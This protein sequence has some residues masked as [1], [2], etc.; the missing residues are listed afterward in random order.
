MAPKK[1]IK[2]P[3]A[4]KKRPAKKVPQKPEILSPGHLPSDSPNAIMKGAAPGAFL[5]FRQ[6]Q[7]DVEQLIAMDGP[8]LR[9][10][11]MK[12]MELASLQ[13]V[14]ISNDLLKSIAARETT[15]DARGM[16][17]ARL[18]QLAYFNESVTRQRVAIQKAGLLEVKKPEEKEK[19]PADLTHEEW[20][21]EYG[22][23]LLSQ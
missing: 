19:D 16:L 5:D 14:K 12:H 10:L 2:K 23:R 21:K 4:K 1:K 20:E 22:S 17:F 7:K 3:K 18:A 11:L 15:E 13:G 9:E 6:M 8:V